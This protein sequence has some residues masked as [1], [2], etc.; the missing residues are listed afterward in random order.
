MI[1]ELV[2]PAP[3]QGLRSEAKSDRAFAKV[4]DLLSAEFLVGFDFPLDLVPD[5]ACDLESGMICTRY[6]TCH[7]FWPLNSGIWFI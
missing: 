6:C 4:R 7:A 1:P 5:E 2:C 3:A